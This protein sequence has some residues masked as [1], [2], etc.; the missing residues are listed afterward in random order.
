VG[1]VEL[2][3]VSCGSEV[4]PETSVDEEDSC[5]RSLVLL[6]EFVSL[7]SEYEVEFEPLFDS[8]VE[9]VS[10]VL[11]DEVSEEEEVTLA[12]TVSEVLTL[13]L[14]PS[15]VEV[16][17]ELSPPAVVEELLVSL[18][19]DESPLEEVS[20]VPA[21]ES[22]SLEEVPEEEDVSAD[23]VSEEELV[24]FVEELLDESDE[25]VSE[26]ALSDAAGSPASCA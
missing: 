22:L 18:V 14:I 9:D 12:S 4:L 19:E 13:S 26:L 7:G 16:P 3:F 21:E 17:V 8:V 2:L 10:E 5:G 25:E 11:F 15:S 6:V 1:S 23:D 24:S 20:F